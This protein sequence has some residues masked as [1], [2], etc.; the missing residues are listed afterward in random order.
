MVD[1]SVSKPSHPAETDSLVVGY[2]PYVPRQ[3]P[4]GCVM[5]WPR[6]SELLLDLDSAQAVQDFVARL[7]L[8]E[9]L[10]GAYRIRIWAS[11][12]K[13]M[14]VWIRSG[15]CLSPERRIALQA[16]LG[17]DWKREMLGI[18]RVVSGISTPSLL[19]KPIRS[20]EPL[21]PDYLTEPE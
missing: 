17:S 4:D 16:A 18:K 7:P 12:R 21:H 15:Y 11:R 14:H 2:T 1:G 3:A 9:E 5:V 10:F 20:N 8:F 6:A 13:G 19:F